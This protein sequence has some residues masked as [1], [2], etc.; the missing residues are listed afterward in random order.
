MKVREIADKLG[1]KPLT[2]DCGLE[3]QIT[4]AYCGDLL[5]W[6]MSHGSK[7]NIWVT[8]QVHP[9]IVAVA[10]LVE[11]SC[12]II[13]EEIEVDKITLEKARQEGIAILHSRDNAYEICGKLKAE[14]V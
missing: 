2:E 10:V 5:S 9:N 11:F 12:I 6:V 3:R 13:P 14:G 4:G 1:L 8:V 7:D